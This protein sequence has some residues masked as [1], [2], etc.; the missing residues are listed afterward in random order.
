MKSGKKLLSS[1]LAALMLATIVPVKTQAADGWSQSGADW[2]YYKNNQVVKGWMKEGWCWY[3]LDYTTGKMKTGWVADGSVWYYLGPSGVMQSE[4]WVVEDGQKYYVDETGAMVSGKATVK[5]EK[6]ASKKVT[7]TFATNGLLTG[8]CVE[9]EEV[10]E[11]KGEWKK[12]GTNYYYYKDGVKQKGWI[13][14]NGK[15]YYLGGDDYHMY[16]GVQTING[17]KYEFANN[18]ALIGEISTDY[19]D[20]YDYTDNYDEK[21]ALYT[22]IDDLRYD[23]DLDSLTWVKKDGLD[24]AAYIRANEIADDYIEERP[25]DE[26]LEDLLEDCD[27]NYEYVEEYYVEATTVSKAYKALTAN[28]QIKRALLDEEHDVIAM[29]RVD[30]I[31][32]ILLADE[33]EESSSSDYGEKEDIADFI[34]YY[35]DDAGVDELELTDDLDKAADKITLEYVK[36]YAAEK[37]DPDYEVI[38]DDYD[39]LYG[40][41]ALI[42]AD[43]A[44]DYTDYEEL[45]DAWMA[46]RTAKKKLLD[47]DYTHMGI[48]IVEYKKVTYIAVVFVEE[49]EFDNDSYYD[50]D[51]ID[52]VDWIN[53]YREENDLDELEL[54][55]DQLDE[56]AYER[57]LELMETYTTKRPDKTK[58]TTILDDYDVEYMSSAQI[59]AKNVTDFEDLVDSWMSES[60]KT[61]LLNEDFTRVGVGIEEYKGSTYVVLL[62]VE[63]EGTTG[64]SDLES[65]KEEIIHLINYLRLANS[66]LTVE[67]GAS[68]AQNVADARAYELARHGYNEEDVE[69]QLDAKKLKY[70]YAVEIPVEDCDTVTDLILEIRNNKVLLDEDV[71]EIV[72]GAGTYRGDTCWSIILYY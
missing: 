72:V 17:K 21:E 15:T 16:W 44:D 49:E 14:I 45:V 30:N 58:Y 52:I 71:E 40:S 57:V 70:T 26:T 66:V 6:D 27:A 1:L 35:R 19:E 36:A 22:L 4:Y 23:E 2:Y 33:K 8:E 64:D 25:D 9:A 61:K 12:E 51:K 11:S 34:N 56:A 65:D 37:E 68:K 41:S 60:S 47:A 46:S 7:C 13:T 43:D 53:Y 31:Y 48:G 62:L 69:D 55:D 20:G 38:L 10:V 39:I 3:F 59:Y 42:F 32:V 63:D 24:L 50:E 28:R 54:A 18:G 67:E 29:G 5:D